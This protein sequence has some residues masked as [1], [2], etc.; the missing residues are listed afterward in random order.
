MGWCFWAEN[1]TD[2][3]KSI[4]NLEKFSSTIIHKRTCTSE[5]GKTFQGEKEQ[6][7]TIIERCGFHDGTDCVFYKNYRGLSFA[8][9]YRFRRLVRRAWQIGLFT[10]TAYLLVRKENLFYAN[11]GKHQTY[12]IGNY[13]RPAELVS[14]WIIYCFE[15]RESGLFGT[16]LDRKVNFRSVNHQTRTVRSFMSTVMTLTLE[17]LQN[18]SETFH[19][20]LLKSKISMLAMD[21][22]M[23]L[24]QLSWGF[25]I[26][27][28]IGALCQWLKSIFTNRASLQWHN[29]HL[30]TAE[31]VHKNKIGILRRSP[32]QR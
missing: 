6:V 1:G 21:W 10:I 17:R 18:Q 8:H 24:M 26:L 15:K 27:L 23:S 22:Q 5:T 14:D 32:W 11:W 20:T 9:T 28:E 25:K 19:C 2:L 7:N 4:L 3:S 30:N 13:A 16:F 29:I 12:N 31:Q